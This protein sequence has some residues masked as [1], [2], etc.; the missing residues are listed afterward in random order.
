MQNAY[1]DWLTLPTG[2]MTI[3][4]FKAGESIHRD[5]ESFKIRTAPTF[6]TTQ[7]LAYC[8]EEIET[9]KTVV[10]TGDTG[11]YKPLATFASVS[12]P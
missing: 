3:E 12:F 6:H 8:I 1:P 4:E 9:G 10:Y 7:S 11:F 5:Y 2:V